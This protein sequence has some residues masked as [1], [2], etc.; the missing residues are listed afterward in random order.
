[1]KPCGITS[2]IS[3]WTIVTEGKSLQLNYSPGLMPF[4]SRVG[5]W[6]GSCGFLVFAIFIPHLNTKHLWRKRDP[7]DLL[8]SSNRELAQFYTKLQKRKKWKQNVD[9]PSSLC[10]KKKK[11]EIGQ[12]GQEGNMNHG[13]TSPENAIERHTFTACWEPRDVIIEIK[14]TI[15]V[16]IV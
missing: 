5:Q 7:L 8:C 6:D 16:S 3:A 14:L 2:L 15:M 11:K 10:C 13:K 4:M 1:M 12:A 9:L